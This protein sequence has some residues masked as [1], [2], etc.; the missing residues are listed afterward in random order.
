MENQ[1]RLGDYDFFL[2]GVEEKWGA[3]KYNP[4]Q[5]WLKVSLSNLRMQ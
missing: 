4:T 5:N 2:Q 3:Q 1:I